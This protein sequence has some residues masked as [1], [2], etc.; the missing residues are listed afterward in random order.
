MLALNPWYNETWWTEAAVCCAADAKARQS[1]L[2]S[3]SWLAAD[4]P[5]AIV[6]AQAVYD[7]PESPQAQVTATAC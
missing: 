1:G 5:D 2:Y 4:L 7:D 3:D 6:A